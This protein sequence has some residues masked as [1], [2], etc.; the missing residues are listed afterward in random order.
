MD[1][2]LPS[3]PYKGGL[4]ISFDEFFESG[5]VKKLQTDC[6]SSYWPQMIAK[7]LCEDDLMKGF[8]VLQKIMRKEIRKNG[9]IPHDQLCEIMR[10][11]HPSDAQA[12]LEHCKNCA[13]CRFISA[14]FDFH[15]FKFD[16]ETLAAAF[17][18]SMLMEGLTNAKNGIYSMNGCPFVGKDNSIDENGFLWI[19]PGSGSHSIYPKYGKMVFA[20]RAGIRLGETYVIMNLIAKGNF[21]S[22]EYHV[23]RRNE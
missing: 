5:F 20:S 17:F 22:G 9:R 2:T 10:S 4:T 16:L 11:I 1:V 3:E 18:I 14:S 7:V 12:Q 13:T 6:P 23:N 15:A 8:A 21:C 19:A